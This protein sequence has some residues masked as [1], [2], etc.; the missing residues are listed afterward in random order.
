MPYGIAMDGA[1]YLYVADLYNHRIRK[2]DPSGMVS[3]V[4]GSGVAGFV[5][6]TAISARFNSPLDL[7]MD[8]A[9]NLIVDD[10]GNHAIR[11]IDPSGVVSTIAGTGV[12]GFADGQGSSAQFDNPGGRGVTIIG[13]ESS[14]RRPN[15][16]HMPFFLEENDLSEVICPN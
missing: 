12:P 3:T 16:G 11:K 5:N 2:I 8:N 15:Q 13:T 7:T 6:G 10:K 4:A 9:G 1:G 14:I